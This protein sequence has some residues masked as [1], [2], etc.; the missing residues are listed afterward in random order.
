[1][2]M[3]KC[4]T[5]LVS[6]ENESFFVEYQIKDSTFEFYPFSNA[7]RKRYKD[8]TRLLVWIPFLPQTFFTREIVL[9]S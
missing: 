8:K 1:M 2:A 5:H 9:S 4:E 6:G 7:H 3:R